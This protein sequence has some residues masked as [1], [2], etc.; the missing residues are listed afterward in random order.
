M[1]GLTERQQEIL[2]FIRAYVA[3]HGYPPIVRE[4]AEPFG[5]SFQGAVRHIN[6]LERKGYLSRTRNKQGVQART[7]SL[8]RS[9]RPVSS[10]GLTYFL[11]PYSP[12]ALRGVYAEPVE[13]GWRNKA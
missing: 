13:I 7:L 1:R 9:E 10:E 11:L 2:D 8:A 12:S 5:F 3:E 4:F 6:A